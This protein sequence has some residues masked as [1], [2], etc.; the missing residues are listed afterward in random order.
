LGEDARGDGENSTTALLRED[1]DVVARDGPVFVDRI[2]VERAE[3]GRG[4]VCP[5]RHSAHAP[6][7]YRLS[8]RNV[9]RRN[10]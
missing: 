6:S 10:L 9:R 5:E 1:R 7:D 8:L 2:R 4:G 3:V